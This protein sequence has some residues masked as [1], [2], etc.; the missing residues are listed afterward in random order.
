MNI[1]TRGAATLAALATVLSLGACADDAADA[2]PRATPTSTP[3]PSASSAEVETPTTEAAAP[4]RKTFE[5]TTPRHTIRTTLDGAERFRVDAAYA[6]RLHLLGVAGTGAEDVPWADLFLYTPTQVHDPET[7]ELRPRPD[8][9]VE[10]LSSNP[11]VRV[12]LRRTYRVDGGPVHEVNVERD[13]SMLFA[14]DRSDDSPGAL[15]RY[16]FRQVDGTWVVGQASTFDGE[17]A[18]ER[19]AARDDVLMALVRSARLVPRG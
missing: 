2:T 13:G 19:R 12:V 4:Q 6:G 18:L 15:E 5:V 17:R 10:W 7:Q 3:S 9:V 14:G 8:D 1:H 16:L 11:G